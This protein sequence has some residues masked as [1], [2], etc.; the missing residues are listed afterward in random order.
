MAKYDSA[1]KECG[2][3]SWFAVERARHLLIDQR[4]VNSR[5]E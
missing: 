2:V 3:L 4:W 5:A 1:L